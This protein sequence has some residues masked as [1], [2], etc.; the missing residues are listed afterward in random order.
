MPN[1]HTPTPWHV[2]ESG[3]I[4]SESRI[5]IAYP[6]QMEAKTANEEREANMEFIVTAVN[7]YSALVE[8]LKAAEMEGNPEV[9]GFCDSCRTPGQLPL[10]TE[11]VP[12]GDGKSYRRDYFKHDDSCWYG[13]VC[14]AIA[15]TE[16]TEV[17]D[18]T[19]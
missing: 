9:E 1:E 5:G 6:I 19:L 18:A 4:F 8:A 14:A 10:V 15:L 16:S 13:K 12:T 11:M 3:A 2:C 7:A 17:K